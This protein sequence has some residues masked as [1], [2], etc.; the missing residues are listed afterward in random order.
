V[1]WTS[2]T[3]DPSFPPLASRGRVA[4]VSPAT[5]Q[6]PQLSDV[7]LITLNVNR[8]LVE[9][10]ASFR[11]LLDGLSPNPDVVFLQE[12]GLMGSDPPG[13]LSL[14]LDKY[15]IF[16]ASSPGPDQAHAAPPFRASLVTLVAKS[17]V[18]DVSL[19]TARRAP[20]GA[21]LILQVGTLLLANTYLP[22]G[23]DWTHPSS[24]AALQARETYEW[25][26]DNIMAAPDMVWVLAGDLNETTIAEER[27]SPS[28][29][30]AP[31]RTPSPSRGR[32][33]IDFLQRVQGV[34]I[35]NGVHTFRRNASS[36]LLDRFIISAEL[37]GGVRGY[38][39]SQVAPLS[40]HSLVRL[41]AS[42]P[43]GRHPR[44]WQWTQKKFIIPTEPQLRLKA[45]EKVNKLFHSQSDRVMQALR[46]CSTS[47]QLEEASLL[48]AETL[49]NASK[50]SFRTTQGSRNR[51]PFRSRLKVQLNSLKNDLVQLAR[52]GSGPHPQPLAPALLRK[53]SK[54]A[55]MLFPLLPPAP[56]LGDVE[57]HAWIRYILNRTRHRI[58]DTY[59][60]L[61]KVQW[62]S[63]VR[64]P[65]LSA[66]AK[67]IVKQSRPPPIT[68]VPHPVT[69]RPTSDPD[70]IKQQL[71]LRVTEPM[72]RPE[73]GPHHLPAGSTPSTP[74]EPGF[75][76]WYQEIYTPLNVGDAWQG[77]CDPPSWEELREL[78][79]NAKKHTSPG[80]GALGVDLLQCCI[81][82]NRS[83]DSFA[84]PGPIAIALVEYVSAVLRVGVYPAWTC[85]AWITTIDK[86]SKD[87][88]DVRPI[89][90]LP[91]LYR[92]ISR[93][94][95]ARLLAVFRKHSI[96]HP[97]QRAGL[98]DG[99]F[100]QC[101]DVV[102][103]IIEDSKTLGTLAL[104]LYDQAKAFDLVTQ[105]NIERAC[106]R[107]GLPRKFIS[108]VTS[109]MQRALAKVRTAF[110]LSEAIK[111]LRSLRQGD[112]LSSIMYCI[113][114]DPLHCLLERL[115]GYK[116]SNGN[117]KVASAA[118]MDDTAVAANSFAELVPLHRGV[119]GFSLLNDGVIN[120]TKSL[121]LLRDHQG[122]LECRVLHTPTGPIIP[123]E[124]PTT[125]AHRY[126]GLWINLGLEWRA[127]DN[128]IKGHFWKI[129]Y[130][131][132]NNKLSTKA[133]R[134][135]INL[136]L[137]PV[138]RQGLRLSRY[139]SQPGI[140]VLNDLQRALNTLL[141][142]NAGCPHPRNWAG[143]IT[144]VLFNT[145]DLRQNA[146]GLNIEALHL[147]LNLPTTTF[148]SAATTR[149]RLT[150]HLAM[151]DSRTPA[152]HGHQTKPSE[153]GLLL[154]LESL[155]LRDLK[156]SL[157][158]KCDIASK[159]AAA[160]DQGLSFQANP[161]RSCNARSF[162]PS[163]ISQ[164]R[165]WEMCTT[166]GVHPT[167]DLVRT[168]MFDEPP[169]VWDI[170]AYEVGWIDE[171]VKLPP[172]LIPDCSLSV[173]TDG[174]AK[175]HED[176]GAAAIFYMNN[177]KLLT[178]RARLRGSKQSFF[179]ECVG[180][181]IA[182]K[183]AP[184]NVETEVICDCRSA[185]FV[186]PKPAAALSWK[187]RL[188]SAGRPA[189]ECI[190]VIMS[191]R[192]ARTEWRWVRAHTIFSDLDV[193]AANNSQVDMQAK[194]ARGLF[195]PPPSEART[196]TWGAE[197]AILT[198]ATYPTLNSSYTATSAPR[199]VMGSVK[200]FL[201]RLQK[202][203]L[204]KEAAKV[205]TMG[206][207]LRYNGDQVLRVVGLLTKFASSKTHAMLAMAL[208]SY[209]P[210]ANRRSWSTRLDPKGGSC[211]W[212]AAGLIQDSPHIFNCPSL[213]LTASANFIEHHRTLQLSQSC[214]PPVVKSTLGS[215]V[216][217]VDALR[218]GL[219]LDLMGRT[220]ELAMI[221]LA[222][223][224]LRVIPH[225]VLALSTA[226]AKHT[227]PHSRGYG[228]DH[229]GT[230]R[231]CIAA[232]WR[233]W[234]TSFR[235]LI[236]CSSPR[237]P[238]SW[239]S[240]PPPAL[241]CALQ[242]PSLPAPFHAVVF[243]GTPAL[244][245]PPTM[246]WYTT[247]DL[248]PNTAWWA[249]QL[250]EVTTTLRLFE[251]APFLTAELLRTR[252]QWWANAVSASPDTLIWAV[253]PALLNLSSLQALHGL[254]CV[255]SH[256]FS[257]QLVRPWDPHFF[258][259][260][261]PAGPVHVKS[262]LL[263]NAF[264]APALQTAWSTVSHTLPDLLQGFGRPPQAEGA[265]SITYA[266]ANW[267]WGP[268]DRALVHAHTHTIPLSPLG[269][270]SACSGDILCKATC[271]S[272][273]QLTGFS[274]YLGNLGIPPTTI[275]D[276][277][278]EAGSS[279]LDGNR[280]P[281]AWIDNSWR[282]LTRLM[283]AAKFLK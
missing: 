211:N 218:D 9:K 260:P 68:S 153:G 110:G 31:S 195:P 259:I 80:E 95:N 58:K 253:V 258:W 235:L 173:Y 207:A 134:L 46:L 244:P 190:R 55:R 165:L 146:L 2:R 166:G 106:V 89:S 90:V 92:L 224:E 53:I 102:T 265:F 172:F 225:S 34:D 11:A 73:V 256:H 150:A 185:L 240:A 156:R 112:P 186:A 175:I 129:F 164:R 59:R 144:S 8:R 78:I 179:P 22:S 155:R 117:L 226:F 37:K 81:Q 97:A 119:L 96:L 227:L 16:I 178:V 197:Q 27:L 152:Q 63:F 86:G 114:I 39:V 121:L 189:L 193:D 201:D 111:L 237:S 57:L 275:T 158:V 36:S 271:T 87:P 13:V 171:L 126:L 154:R 105:T 212:C 161:L 118:F 77:L 238:D 168:L 65:R 208:A 66:F 6:A 264:M 266:P 183:F 230:H 254:T 88:L 245:P 159:L 249:D 269:V 181:L 148:P 217:H 136:W 169:A 67:K 99:D 64:A 199:Q 56:N 149:S 70:I 180:C 177:R 7:S 33:I 30:S 41:L 200:G 125:E 194:T 167:A 40:D 5:P 143:P 140:K 21:A 141:A 282:G 188:T 151:L 231:V 233:R 139:I 45:Y 128:K 26:A 248:R 274:R 192:M 214:M 103:S 281:P 157:R 263:R 69:G 20:N 182:I 123:V 104:V 209:L 257:I 62:D 205:A 47:A 232:E 250:S 23:L 51:R 283:R 43:V 243:N 76:D 28:S 216:S 196:W 162:V 137:L 262:V 52:L 120:N 138:Y 3:G 278:S 44:K 35:S 160:M 116:F 174:S 75:P 12:A 170:Q 84:T 98:S 191:L 15:H 241:W 222:L 187:N 251:W 279:L 113:Y 229:D 130:T 215:V 83:T 273:L 210:L 142:R 48:F 124:E 74:P 115:G 72:R 198:T 49:K 38:E 221:P 19:I 213:M 268:T 94:L 24:A 14:V 220:S 131:I 10:L 108:L 176:A 61:R 223:D 109:A 122:P 267:W 234:T 255:E 133:A 1:I 204:A 270:R 280:E 203:N 101:I 32:F 91:E 42:L 206:K 276:L 4:K 60:A 261:R 29:D 135:V 239:N 236:E 145:K 252:A 100:L 71:L 85:T 147:N 93:V 242:D 202:V 132:K 79:G 184:I 219:A 18:P 17:L 246:V 82:P 25:L 272:S 277:F 54:S 127:M 163:V 247:A 228:D 107:I 50:Q